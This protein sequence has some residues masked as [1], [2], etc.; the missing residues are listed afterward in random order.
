M[1][2]K[3]WRG[4]M[5]IDDIQHRDVD[6]SVIWE[7]KNL[8]NLLHLEGEEFLLRAAFTG[9]TVSDVIPENYYAGLDARDDIEFGDSMTDISGEPSSSGYARQ[10][11]SS[12]G[13]FTVQFAGGNFSAISPIIVFLAIGGGWGPA[14]NLFFTD[15]EDNSGELISSTAL[16][17]PI[18]L[19]AGQSITLRI[20]MLLRDCTLCPST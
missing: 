9:G 17:S 4:I 16:S 5:K 19:T 1:G 15:K 2:N 18:T 20:R 12:S 6:G 11:I 7:D 14:S 10:A 8:H 3:N 13:D